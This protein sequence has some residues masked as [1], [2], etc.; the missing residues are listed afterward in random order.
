MKLVMWHIQRIDSQQGSSSELVCDADY[1]P[2]TI[3]MFDSDTSTTSVITL[4]KNRTSV[5][6]CDLMDLLRGAGYTPAD[7]DTECPGA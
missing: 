5:H 7:W 1:D 2:V 6:P 3:T 4:C